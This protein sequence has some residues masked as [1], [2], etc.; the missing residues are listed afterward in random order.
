MKSTLERGVQGYE[1]GARL[2]AE[3]KS[4]T[5]L[6]AVPLDVV[7]VYSTNYSR[8]IDTVNS[9]LVGLLPVPNG[10]GGRRRLAADGHCGCRPDHGDNATQ[11]C[12]AQCLDE[13]PRD[14]LPTVHVRPITDPALHQ[15]RACKG[16][17]SYFD[18]IVKKRFSWTHA[19]S[20]QFHEQWLLARGVSGQREDLK[21]FEWPGH[22]CVGCVHPR[23]TQLE[24]IESVRAALPHARCE[25]RPLVERSSSGAMSGERG[26]R[27]CGATRC[28]TRQ[29][30]TG[31]PTR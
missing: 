17:A 14:G 11:A 8:T 6:D 2:H 16:W 23:D 12:V 26:A 1:L 21:L 13:P 4:A 27:R 9:L 20:G 29:R 15:T 5:G 28:A 22:K 24:F 31:T 25:L 18:T 30:A 10:E 19:A 3:Y 7:T